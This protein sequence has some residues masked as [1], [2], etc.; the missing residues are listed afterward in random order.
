MILIVGASGYIGSE[1]IRQMNLN[2]AQ[3]RTGRH[4]EYNTYRKLVNLIQDTNV[5][6]VINC[7][8]FIKN[9][10]VDNN[11]DH[12]ADNLMGNLVF[13]TNL[14][15]ACERWRVPLL[16]VSTGCL[17]N[18][19]NEGRG[20]SEADEP[21]LSFR[22]RPD[23]GVYVGAKQLAEEVV[24]QYSNVWIARV[25]LPFD[26]YDHARNYISKLIR[27]ERV[28]DATNS[29]SHRGD[30]VEACLKMISQRVPYGTYNV[31]NEGAISAEEITRMIH[32][33]DVRR[34][35]FV[36][37]DHDEFLSRC[38]RTP[39]SNCLLNV[40]KLAGVGIKMRPVREAVNDSLK[41]WVPEK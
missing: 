19:D 23:V 14:V 31:T 30:F 39:K 28:F 37:W 18:G 13:P 35:E 40:E 4:S 34:K 29:L 7:A 1:F 33:Y 22:L 10:A 25:R 8:A 3:F 12:K 17:Y 9:G 20:W 6:L 21:Q 24:R 15:N 2:H 27:Y 5:K 11:E 38:A 26:R 36:W 32:W 16:H 41:N